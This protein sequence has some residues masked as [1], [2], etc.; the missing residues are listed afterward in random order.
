[1]SNCSSIFCWKDCTFFIEFSS[2]K[3]FDHVC[4]SLYLATLFRFLNLFL[5]FHANATL[6]DDISKTISEQRVLQLCSIFSWL[7]LT[8]LD[9]F[10]FDKNLKI[11]LLSK[12]CW[13]F[14]WDFIESIDHLKENGTLKI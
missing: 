9:N 2:L 12:S 11:S 4:L 14:N 10:H 3:L 8:I 6:S 5:Y 1:M 7:F 13:D